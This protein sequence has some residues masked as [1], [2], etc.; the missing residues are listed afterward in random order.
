[1][2]N[3]LANKPYKTKQTN[4]GTR[5]PT[6]IVSI[7]GDKNHMQICSCINQSILILGLGFI[8]NWS[9]RTGSH[10]IWSRIN[11]KNEQN[12][13]AKLSEGWMSNLFIGITVLQSVMTV[14]NLMTWGELL[15]TAFSNSTSN[16]GNRLVDKNMKFKNWHKYELGTVLSSSTS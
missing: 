1:M 16:Q 6:C 9:A 4:L 12:M 10:S 5:K 11:A 7:L 8:Q 3:Y 15:A 2:S 14:K 13:W